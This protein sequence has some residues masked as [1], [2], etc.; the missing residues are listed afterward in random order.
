MPRKLS[1]ALFA[2]VLVCFFL[3]FVS[4]S[5][6]GQKIQ[7]FSGIRL[8]T[9]TSVKQPGMLGQ[10]Q[11]QKVSPEPSAIVAFLFV[12]AGIA[13]GFT[14]ARTADI[15]SA[16]SATVG[17]VFLFALQSKLNGEVGREGQGLIQVDYEIGFYLAVIMLLFTAVLNVFLLMQSK[18][19]PVPQLSRGQDH[20]FCTQCGS[21]NKP[22]DLFCKECGAK[23]A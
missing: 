19:I 4:V 16:F 13:A 11:T 8:V 9:G 21:R 15:A 2:L 18:A 5:C 12:L 7:T 1:P 10:S 3:P 17:V 14:K 6:A 22:S 20:K 23:F